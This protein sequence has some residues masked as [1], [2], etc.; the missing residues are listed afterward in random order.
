MTKQE[1]IS[2]LEDNGIEYHEENEPDWYA[3][4]YPIIDKDNAIEVSIMIKDHNYLVD[5]NYPIVIPWRLDTY[6]DEEYEYLNRHYRSVSE[7]AYLDE[8]GETRYELM[9]V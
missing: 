3:V 5:N 9:E 2:V 6:T 4:G 1:L 8:N 7:V